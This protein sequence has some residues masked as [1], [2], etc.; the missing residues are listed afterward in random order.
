MTKTKLT[1][2]ALLAAALIIGV[3]TPAFNGLSLLALAMIGG[4]AWL[5][6]GRGTAA[7][8]PAAAE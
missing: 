1:Q 8:L 3:T 4:A 5:A 6:Q 2:I 7:V